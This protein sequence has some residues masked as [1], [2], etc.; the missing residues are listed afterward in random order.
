MLVAALR[1]AG[2]RVSTPEV[3]D[4]LHAIG[5]V[6]IERPRMR[7]ALAACLTKDIAD[8][9]DFDL[10]FDSIFALPERR[11]IKRDRRD[12]EPEPEGDGG[13]PRRSEGSNPTAPAE[14]PKQRAYGHHPA[15]SASPERQS[16]SALEKRILQ[17]RALLEVP[18]HDLFPSDLATHADL[19]EEIARRFH[20]RMRRRTASARRRRFDI[21]KT[22]RQS[23]SHG[24]VPMDLCFGHPRPGR[25]NLLA[26]CDLSHSVA[27]AAHFLLS[28]LTAS[29]RLFRR[30][31]L[32]AYVD[33][34]VKVSVER[35][36]LVPHTPL[37]LHGRSDLGRALVGF[38]ARYEGLVNRNTIVLILGDAS[39]TSTIRGGES[40]SF[41]DL[42][43]KV[44]TTFGP[45]A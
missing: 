36:Q 43:R 13:S 35:G 23:V 9:A 3:L 15:Q 45:R 10:T 6:G 21:R 29:T 34:P 24:G 38:A 44:G 2:L 28:L 26:F 11:R 5:A 25:L 27:T 17:Q 42:G 16:P 22:L 8:R 32:F 19:L 33:E 20:R 7:E 37:D 12:A 18:F 31:D 30:T 41:K 40:R 4:A 39:P 14:D 1:K